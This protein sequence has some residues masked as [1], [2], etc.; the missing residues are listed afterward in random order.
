M[1]RLD[2]F[3]MLRQPSL[4][5]AIF[6]LL[7]VVDSSWGGNASFTAATNTSPAY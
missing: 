1:T 7:G 6:V 3:S 5:A 4:P 2:S